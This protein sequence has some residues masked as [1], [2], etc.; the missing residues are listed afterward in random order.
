M[1]LFLM[2]LLFFMINDAHAQEWVGEDS[3]CVDETNYYA[4]VLTG[5]N[6][7]QNTTLNGNRTSYQTGYIIAGSLGYYWCYGLSV[8]AEYAFRRNG[9]SKIE[10]FSEGSSH[11][12]YFETSSC[13]A[14]L[15]WD[16]PLSLWECVL[17]NAQP[18]IGVGIGCDFQ[19]MH[20]SNSLIVF[21]QNWTHLS[22]QLMAGLTYPFY[23]DTE[24][25]LEYKFHQGGC[26]FYNHTLGVGLIYK[27]GCL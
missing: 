16:V 19:H 23:C 3:C 14:N 25:T 17:G 1:L 18:F 13:M 8:E 12:G 9:I 26:H 21:N 22:W 7:L 2:S 20:S 24:L 27:F 4:K 6:F 15:L 5:I 10:F 11:S